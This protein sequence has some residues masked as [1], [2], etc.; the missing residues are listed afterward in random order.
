MK[1]YLA[2]FWVLWLLFFSMGTA[3]PLASGYAGFVDSLASEAPVPPTP[4]EV[5]ANPFSLRNYW[6]QDAP[7]LETYS[8]QAMA[9]QRALNERE[10]AIWT[11][12]PLGQP[13]E[14]VAID[15]LAITPYTWK[16]VK[17]SVIK[18]DQTESLISLRRPNQW[19]KK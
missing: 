14:W 2:G 15:S 19:L 5:F 12:S 1:K 9:M 6:G 10:E 8:P 7:R 17:L 4:Q 18:K 13:E 16:W 11:Y 3:Q